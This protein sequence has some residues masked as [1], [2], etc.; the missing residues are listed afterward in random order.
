MKIYTGK[1]DGGYT[2]LLNQARVSKTDDRIELLGMID[3]LNSHIGLAKVQANTCLK[4][5]L[6]NIQ[7][8][9]IKVMAGIADQ[10]NEQYKISESEIFVLEQKIDAKE[11]L[12]VRKRGFVLYGGCELSARL[13]VARAVT[14][15][16]ERQ[17]FRCARIYPID[18]YA[19]KY[20]NR[21]SDYLYVC[22]RLVDYYENND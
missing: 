7:N 6:I 19:V 16:C 3:E 1:G 10:A 4:D 18:M 5:E 8:M 2:S 14:R 9:L 17:F 12:H 21:L 11:K 22:A 15:R 13:D 20:M